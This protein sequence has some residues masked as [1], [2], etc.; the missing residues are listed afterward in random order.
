MLLYKSPFTALYITVKAIEVSYHVM[1][2]DIVN[3]NNCTKINASAL[4]CCWQGL[5]KLFFT[6]SHDLFLSS[7]Y[8]DYDHYNT[9]GILAFLMMAASRH[10]WWKSLIIII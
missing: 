2:I 10:E 3:V 9:T 7:H 4:L 6:T 8:M 5:K 1:L